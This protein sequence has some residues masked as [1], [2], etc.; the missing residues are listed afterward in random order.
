MLLCGPGSLASGFRVIEGHITL[1]SPLL[2]T[3]GCFSSAGRLSTAR[4]SVNSSPSYNS[5]SQII[6]HQTSEWNLS[7]LRV[8]FIITFYSPPSTPSAFQFSSIIPS[9]LQPLLAGTPH[10]EKSSTPLAL[11]LLL[12]IILLSLSSSTAATAVTAASAESASTAAGSSV[13]VTA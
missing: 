9:S 2:G 12:A 5:P 1:A 10:H 11:D 7:R 8:F 13:Y 3:A 4:L 6:H